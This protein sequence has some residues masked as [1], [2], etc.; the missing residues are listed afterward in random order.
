MVVCGHNDNM[1]TDEQAKTDILSVR[2]MWFP[3]NINIHSATGY[4]SNEM[5]SSKMGKYLPI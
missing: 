3:A 5:G 2:D 4:G 1:W